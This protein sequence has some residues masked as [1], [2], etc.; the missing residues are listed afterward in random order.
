MSNNKH[1][2]A[3][4]VFNSTDFVFSS[5]GTFEQVFPQIADITIRVK[6]SGYGV[7]PGFDTRTY[8]KSIGEYVNCSNP[9]CYNGGI[10]V[11][12]IIHEMVRK[13]D[14]HGEEKHICQGYEGSPKG[15]RR[16]RS[17]INF[18]HVTIDIKYKDNNGEKPI[19]VDPR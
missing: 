5:K 6:E 8:T 11:G 10:R 4:D 19:V 2:K 13:G 1:M 9:S 7:T 12:S 16:Y 15:H 3:Q 14:T 18:F 17:C